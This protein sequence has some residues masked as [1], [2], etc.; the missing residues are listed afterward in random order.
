M[1]MHPA[2]I[3]REIQAYPFFLS[4]D[5]S[6]LLQVSTMVREVSFDAGKTILAPGETNNTLYFMRQGTVQIRV[7]KKS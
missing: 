7:T 3:A 6:L 4:F 2:E 5:E 1:Q